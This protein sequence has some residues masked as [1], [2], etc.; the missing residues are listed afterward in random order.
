MT[1]DDSSFNPHSGLLRV[2]RTMFA[3]RDLDQLLDVI[4]E[5]AER[6]LSAERCSVFLIDEARQQLWSR[7]ASGLDKTVLRFPATSGL[8]GHTWKT[9]ETL[10]IANAYQDARFNPE[11]DR[12]TGFQTRSVLCMPLTAHDGET[13]GVF[14]V[15]NKLPSGAFTPQDEMLA[16]ALGGNAAIAIENAQLYQ[17]QRDAFNSF[18]LTLSSTIDARDPI[19]AGHSARVA[20]YSCLLGEAMRLPG[21]ELEALRI[22]SLLHDIG[23]IGI[24]EDVLTKEGRLTVGEYRH[25]QTH[26]A[27]TY[28]ILKN[29]RFERRLAQIPEIAA[30]HHEKLD[31]TG[32]FRGVTGQHIPLP[33][34][35]L[36]LGDVF[37]AITS[38]RH[39]RQ[40]MRFEKVVAI[41]RNDAGTHFDPAC[42]EAWLGLPVFAIA[43]V[44]AQ[45]ETLCDPLDRQMT[46]GELE[47]IL[48]KTSHTRAEQ[49]QIEV[50]QRVYGGPLA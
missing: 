3:T 36:A 14:Q 40:P 27:K 10:N 38:R 26:V 12:L 50:F 31:G 48:L 44:M 28:E 20:D 19:T 39:Y 9:G 33:G 7:V 4:K 43:R 47:A 22:A 2:A 24:R 32:Y 25:I 49:Q 18:V 8:A 13:I 29:I 17:A 46:V 5:E 35:V 23:K 30:S 45:T 34:R 15:L 21:H 1:L 42:V 11:L 41:L 16:N 37:D 6:M